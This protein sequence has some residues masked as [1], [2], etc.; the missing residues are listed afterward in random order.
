MTQ[1]EFQELV[2]KRFTLEITDLF[3]CYI[4]DNKDLLQEYQRVIGRDSD[5]DSTNKALGLVVKEWFNLGNGD[6]NQNPKSKLIRSYTEHV[7]R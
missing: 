5:L 4:E 7:K 2:L 1:T 6:V 3:F